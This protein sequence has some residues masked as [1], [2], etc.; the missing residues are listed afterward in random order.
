MNIIISKSKL[1]LRQLRCFSEEF[2]RQKVK[3]LENK[4]ITISQIVSLYGVSR[5]S[6]YRWIHKYSLHSTKGTR[7]VIEMESESQKTLYLQK[8]VSELEQAVGR[9]QIEIDYL[10]KLIELASLDLDIDIKKN[11]STQLSSGSE[12]IKST[13]KSS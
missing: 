6:I 9:K 1:N 5:S 13:Q 7:K 11:F 2:K 12:S 10:N 3:E 4:Q 8:Q